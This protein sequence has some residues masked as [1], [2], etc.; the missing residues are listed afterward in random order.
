VDTSLDE[1]EIVADFYT[2]A[3]GAAAPAMRR[4]QERLRDAWTAATRD[5]RDV[6]C[7]SGLWIIVRTPV[8]TYHLARDFGGDACAK[9]L[10]NQVQC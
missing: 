8:V 7:N 1:R 4:F 2:R 10:L 5:G 6:S 9:V 3:F